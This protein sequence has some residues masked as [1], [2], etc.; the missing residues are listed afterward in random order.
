MQK[1][2]RQQKNEDRKRLSDSQNFITDQRLIGRLIRLSSIGREDTVVEIGTGKGHLTEEMCRRGGIVYSVE[3]DRKL[4]EGTKKKLEGYANLH[5]IHGDFLTYS[6]PARG[7][8]KV[9]ANIPYFITTQSPKRDL[10][11]N[12]ERR[13]E[14]IYGSGKRNEEISAPE[15]KMGHEDPV[16][17]QAGRFSSQTFRRFRSAILCQKE[18]AGFKQKRIRGV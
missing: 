18:N 1:G 4:Y 10:A 6:L 9:F 5:L 11:R 13:G 7:D 17:F 2:R 12:G 3:L 14:E 8:Y 16:S 15:G